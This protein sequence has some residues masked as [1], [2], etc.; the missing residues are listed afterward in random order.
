MERIQLLHPAFTNHITDENSAFIEELKVI[1]VTK[2]KEI[3]NKNNLLSSRL[4][5][6]VWL[7]EKE[8]FVWHVMLIIMTITFE[9]PL[10]ELR[11]RAEQ[12]HGTGKR[13]AKQCTRWVFASQRF[14]GTNPQTW[15]SCSAGILTGRKGWL[16]PQLGISSPNS[17]KTCNSAH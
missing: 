3:K 6:W 13:I 5:T 8:C 12:G 7:W 9:G 14:D 16:A 15:V 2:I 1:R 11:K 17:L 4:G 10:R